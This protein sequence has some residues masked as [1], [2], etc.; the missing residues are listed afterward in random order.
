MDGSVA[1]TAGE[2]A[3]AV[4][5]PPRRRA[6]RRWAARL[7]VGITAVAVFVSSIAVW[8]HR[9][10]LDTDEWVATI[11]PLADDPEVTRAVAV[12][13]VDQALTAVDVEQRAAEALPDQAAFLAR[14]LASALRD[15][16][17][18][19]ATGLLQTEQFRVLWV[20]AN[21]VAHRRV[22]QL[23]TGA[24]TANLSP[25]GSVTLNLVPAVALLLERMDALGILPASFAPPAV[26]WGAPP[27]HSI[28]DLADALGVELS[29]EF[30]QVTVFRSTT[31]AL[32]QDSVALFERLAALSVAVALALAASC[33]ALAADRRRTIVLLGLSTAGAMLLSG[34]VASA[35]A[36][37]VV[38]LVAEGDERSA[39]A[40]VG[41]R[42]VGSLEDI[43]SGLA[44]L[45]LLVAGVA[46][47]SGTSP[48]ARR[49]R[50]WARPSRQEGSAA[51]RCPQPIRS[52]ATRHRDALSL[53]AFLMALLALVV[54][55][56]SFAAVAVVGVVLVALLG[57]LTLLT[58][59]VRRV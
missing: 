36:E 8:S 12:Y 15:Q 34:V 1:T 51:A 40:A 13:L 57:V 14:P 4:T 20:E 43:T 50:A 35:A 21:R 25:D 17:T 42:V 29:P 31:L 16:L 56:P 33:V 10:L 59:P 30:G 24:S 58:S 28:A 38:H 26:D 23:L 53:T 49:L 11:G 46:F 2:A 39:A 45:G 37:H 54:L 48:T 9:V 19:T 32:V 47:L 52:V 7:L 44:L 27:A 3:A 5:G 41:R 55:P 6:V 18:E 22:V